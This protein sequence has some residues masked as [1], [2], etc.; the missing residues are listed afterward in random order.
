MFLGSTVHLPRHQALPEVLFVQN[1]M[2]TLG[3][4]EL[5]ELQTLLLINV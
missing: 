2:W 3:G 1:G 5:I 4:T